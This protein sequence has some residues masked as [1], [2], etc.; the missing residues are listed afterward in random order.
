MLYIGIILIGL[1][2]LKLHSISL[3]TFIIIACIVGFARSTVMLINIRNENKFLKNIIMSAYDCFSCDDQMLY[4]TIKKVKLVKKKR[5]IKLL[6]H[7]PREQKLV[8][9]N[10]SKK[11]VDIFVW[12]EA[13]KKYNEKELNNFLSEIIKEKLI[14]TLPPETLSDLMYQ[15]DYKLCD[16]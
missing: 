5:Y 16:P 11:S 6:V 8:T 1:V 4:Q 2:F 7:L 10:T 14:G 13:I 12:R 3:E 9:L 15:L